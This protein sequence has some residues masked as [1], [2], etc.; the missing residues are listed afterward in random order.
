MS[1]KVLVFESDPAFAGELR[2]ELAKLGCS[3][4]VVDD[5]NVGLLSNLACQ[6]PAP[7]VDFWNQYGR[8]GGLAGG[9]F[10]TLQGAGIPAFGSV[11][12]LGIGLAAGAFVRRRRRRDI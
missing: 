12:G 4:T 11:F 6:T 1:T 3:T 8:A 5:G 2:N 10:C 7:V 9:G